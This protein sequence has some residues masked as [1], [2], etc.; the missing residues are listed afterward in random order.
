M[1][2]SEK[3]VLGTV[4]ALAIY[5]LWPHGAP[6][7]QP[8][9]AFVYTSAEACRQSGDMGP[10][11]CDTE[12][13]KASDQHISTA[14]KF[15]DN[16]D[17]E[18]SHGSAQC[19]VTTWN[20]ANVFVPAMVGYMISRH[21][22]SGN[23]AARVSQPLFP[24]GPGAQVCPSGFDPQ[25]RP[26]CV[27]SKSNSSSS[28][29]GSSSGRSSN[30]TVTRWFRTAAGNVIVQDSRPSTS[31]GNAVVPRT[32]TSAPAAR[33]SVISRGGFGSTGSSIGRSSG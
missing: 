14:P 6:K 20:G 4:G 8:A 28:S 32:T 3:I 1:K 5:G 2:R 22:T 21:M 26:D 7:E 10:S 23:T 11:E 25:L 24:G 16:A 31:R 18:K 13:A 27:Q 30:R 12:W 17:C 15:T 29:T 19:R 33:T 9:D